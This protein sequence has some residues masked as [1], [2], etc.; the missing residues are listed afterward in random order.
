MDATFATTLFGL[1]FL[2]LALMLALSLNLQRQISLGQQRLDIHRDDLDD[3]FTMIC[4]H[5]RRINEVEET[6]DPVACQNC[7]GEMP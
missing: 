4:R 6:L 7:P 5:E 1:L 2:G 3:H